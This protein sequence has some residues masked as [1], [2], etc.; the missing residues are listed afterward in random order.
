ML[1][2]M[3]L[4]QIKDDLGLK[5]PKS[6]SSSS[7]KRDQKKFAATIKITVITPMNVVIRRNK[8]DPE[9]KAL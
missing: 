1:A 9:G 2:N 5:W 6:L 3:I 7:K 8:F 4:M